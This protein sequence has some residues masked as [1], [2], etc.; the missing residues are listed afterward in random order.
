MSAGNGNLS[1]Q[2][3]LAWQWSYNN[4]N[5]LVIINYSDL[6][7]QC[8]IK[9]ESKSKRN[10]IILHDQLNVKIFDRSVSE[11]KNPG[12]FIEL[13]GFASHIFTFNEN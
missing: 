1:F 3:F 2:N 5:A 9:I 4:S 10:F 12:L 11:I 7:S 6:T 13:K 8:R